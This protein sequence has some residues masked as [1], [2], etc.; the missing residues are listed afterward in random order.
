MLTRNYWLYK[1]YADSHPI[2]WDWTSDSTPD[3]GVVATDGSTSVVIW[4]LSQD[5]HNAYQLGSENQRLFVNLDV[6]LG[7]GNTA[8]TV[9]DYMLYGSLMSHIGNYEQDIDMHSDGDTLK[10]TILLSGRNTNVNPITICEIG[11]FKKF[12]YSYTAYG[13]GTQIDTTTKKT[14]F[15]REVLQ[16]PITVAA[17]D[18]FVLPFAWVE[19]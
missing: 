13:D 12:Y 11:I 18:S 17:N 8:P 16:S 9:N 4:T 3:F 15:L 10:T 7:T 5:F 14:L 2:P 19:S 6:E 1:E